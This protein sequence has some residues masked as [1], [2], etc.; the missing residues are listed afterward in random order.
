[1]LL[2]LIL[3]FAVTVPMPSHDTSSATQG[4][5]DM[6]ESCPPDKVVIVDS[7]WDMSSRAECR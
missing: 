3:P 6:L 4:L 7:S 5:Y 1:M 2:V